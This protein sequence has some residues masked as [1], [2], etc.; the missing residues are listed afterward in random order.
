MDLTAAEIR[1]L[2]CLIEKER[3]TPDQYPMTTNALRLGCNQKT[4]RA[5]V[6]DFDERTVDAAMLTLRERRLARTVLGG[7]RAAKHK[8]IADETLQ[9]SENELALLGVLAVRGPQTPG[10]LRT[11]TER[12]ASFSSLEDVIGVLDGL[13]ERQDP[14]VAV[15]ERRPGQKEAR[16]AHLL[17]GEVVDVDAE[18]WSGDSSGSARA[19]SSPLT[20]RVEQLEEDVRSLTSDLGVLRAQFDKLCELLDATVD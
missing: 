13:I 2:G 8:H 12:M 9:V 5:P 4:N 1:V 7:A 14:L 10:E 18:P 19:S 6:V 15:L 11:R 3:T 17:A 16:Y 20:G